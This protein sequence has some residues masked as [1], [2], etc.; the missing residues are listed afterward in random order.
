[1]R[2]STERILVS[3][4]GVL[5]RP[6]G[7]QRLFEAGP[8]EQQAFDAALPAAVADVVARQVA[9]G[10]DIVNDGEV[11]KRGLFIGYIRDRMSG[12]EERTVSASEFRPRQPGLPRLLRG[13]VR[14]LPGPHACRPGRDPGAGSTHDG[15]CL[16]RPAAVHG[17]GRRQGRHRPADRGRGSG[18]APGPTCPRSRPARSSTGC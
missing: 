16:H 2:R 4:A 9:A 18:T 14:R 13:R 10:V 15:A 5:P 7:L 12:F 3:H 6:E 1:M 11:S 8:R 17:R